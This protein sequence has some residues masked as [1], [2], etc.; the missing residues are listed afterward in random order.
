MSKSSIHWDNEM[1]KHPR[2]LTALLLLAACTKAASAPIATQ[3]Y[4]LLIANGTVIDGTGDA[5]YQ[6]DVAVSGARVVRVERGSIPRA[7]AK[8]VIDATGLI[9]APGFIDLHAHLDPLPLMP[10]AQSAAM[11]G[12]VREI[13]DGQVIVEFNSNL[14]AIKPGMNADV[15]LKVE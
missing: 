15:R 10:D 11:Q 13:K 6:A 9:V 2:S 1:M 3:T 12:A 14:P 8:R 5:R 4:D 7:S